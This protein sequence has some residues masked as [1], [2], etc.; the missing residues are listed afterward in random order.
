M[1]LV[2]VVFGKKPKT[3][4]CKNNKQINT[5]PCRLSD[6]YNISDS[7][8]LRNLL[9]LMQIS[10]SVLPTLTAVTSMQC[11]AIRL[12]RTHACVKQDLL[13]MEK[14]APV[15]CCGNVKND[16]QNDVNVI[17][18]LSICYIRSVHEKMS[19]KKK[20]K[21]KEKKMDMT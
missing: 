4:F 21:K 20:G 17:L 7:N 15:S 19:R 9:V 13:A 5:R 8:A 18:C 16:F 6:R 10:T 3:R 14:L 2:H 1:S 12:D 11:V